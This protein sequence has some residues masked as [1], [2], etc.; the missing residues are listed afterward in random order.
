LVSDKKSTNCPTFES[1][2]KQLDGSSDAR[3]VL[4]FIPH[5]DPC[6]LLIFNCS[7][8]SCTYTCIHTT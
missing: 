8:L 4:I 3:S 2:K 5:A 1:C 7:Y 6:S